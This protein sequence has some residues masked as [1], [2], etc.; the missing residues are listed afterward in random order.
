MLTQALILLFLSLADS[1]PCLCADG[2]GGLTHV[3][4]QERH[5]DLPDGLMDKTAW[6]VQ[7]EKRDTLL[8]VGRDFPRAV[9][10]HR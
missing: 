9:L 3:T 5:A 7:R 1:A 2:R 10:Y 8:I 4:G 6:L